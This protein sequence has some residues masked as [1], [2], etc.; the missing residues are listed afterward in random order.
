[1]D[2][3]DYSDINIVEPI[4]VTVN[5][6]ELADTS[7][8]TSKKPIPIF[9]FLRNGNGNNGN[10]SFEDYIYSNSDSATIFHVRKLYSLDVGI[11]S[12]FMKNKGDFKKMFSK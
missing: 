5:T 2:Y 10:N 12:R 3:D 11:Y 8:G 4:I 1:L 6:T 7:Y 9:K